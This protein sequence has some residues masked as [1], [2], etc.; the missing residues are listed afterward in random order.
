MSN[1]YIF[2]T[3][4]NLNTVTILK[5]KLTHSSL[6]FGHN[7]SNNDHRTRKSKVQQFS[8]TN[9]WDK[10]VQSPPCLTCSGYNPLSLVTT[11]LG[12]DVLHCWLLLSM[13]ANH[14]TDWIIT[15]ILQKVFFIKE[16][17]RSITIYLCRSC[18]DKHRYMLH[19]FV[20]PLKNKW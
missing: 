8:R 2:T 5:N 3:Q 19:V 6:I 12:S 17:S 20:R 18:I 13:Y 14:K 9:M 4:N 16:M 15:A 10:Q 11:P 7:H 1:S